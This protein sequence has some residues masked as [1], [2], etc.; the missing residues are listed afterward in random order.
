MNSSDTGAEINNQD[1]DSLIKTL[2]S[3]DG[4][5]R[6][7]ARNTL[8][9][10]GEPA[11]DAL[12][13]AFKIK[14][15]PMHWEVAKALSRIGTSR[16]AQ[17]LVDALEDHDFS[18]RWIAA[19]GLIHI[20]YTGLIPLLEALRKKIDSVWLREG[21]HHIIHDLINRKLVDESTRKVLGPVLE[22]LSHFDAMTLKYAAVDDALKAIH[23]K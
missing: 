11:L 18:V 7:R 22:T 17:V 9:E 3:K 6:Q 23:I 13:E 19:E 21:G 5:A 10:I 15:E 14:E 8:V 16:A 4:I 12:I 2:K 1:I 20:G